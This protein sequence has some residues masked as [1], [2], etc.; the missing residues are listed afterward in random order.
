MAEDKYTLVDS[1][2]II[3]ML[4]TYLPLMVLSMRKI[5]M[6]WDKDPE[7]VDTFLNPEYPFEHSFDELSVSVRKW[8]DDALNRINDHEYQDNNDTNI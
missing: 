6:I 1:E 8:C 5:T 4:R 7:F 2:D 3:D